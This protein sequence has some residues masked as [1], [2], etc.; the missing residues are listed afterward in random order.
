MS[1]PENAPAG[2][3]PGRRLAALD[4]LR[5]VAALAVLGYH[6]TGI[7]LDYWGVPSQVMFPGLSD[8]TKYGYLGVELFFIISGFVILM[9][10]YDRSVQSFVA[11]RISRLFPAYWVAIIITLVLQHF[12]DGGRNPGFLDGL[13]NL[14]MVQ[15]AVDVPDVQGA[16][17]T[18]WYELKFYLLIGVFVVVGMTRQRVLAFAFLWPLVG[19]IAAATGTTILQS[20][21]FPTY[22]PY[23]AAGMCLYV[24]HREGHDLLAWLILGYNVVLCERQAVGYAERAGRLTDQSMS[25]LLLGL[26]VLAMV[27]AVYACTH[28]PLSRIQ[29]P[30]LTLAGVL[31]YPLYL[32]HGQFGFFLIDVLHDRLPRYAVLGVTTVIVIVMAYVIHRLVEKPL[33]RPLR[34]AVERALS[35]RPWEGLSRT[36]PPSV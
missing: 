14:T 10:A 5:L 16:F 2:A 23:F 20:L 35:D 32:V 24:I 29:W 3:Q 7:D 11:S 26:A 4:G 25:P 21:L 15:G 27:I 30:W 6:Y 28:G 17:W 18:L 36:R 1:A 12:W 31:T 13:V 33:A 22:A 19:L 9:T 34:R 8:L